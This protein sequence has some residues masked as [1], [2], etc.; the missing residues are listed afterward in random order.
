MDL[1]TVG[2]VWLNN[3]NGTFTATNFSSPYAIGSAVAVGDFNGDQKL[4][5]AASA[6]GVSIFLGHGNGRLVFLTNYGVGGTALAMADFDGNTRSDLVTL[7][8]YS[9]TTVLSGNG[10]GTFAPPAN[11]L[12]SPYYRYCVATG[13]FNRDGK[14]DIVTGS[15]VRS[16]SVRLNNGDGTFG[17]QKTVQVPI[18]VSAL[19]VADFDGDGNL[20]IVAG[21]PLVILPGNGDGTFASP[22]TN[23]SN[24]SG[25][26]GANQNLVVADFDGDGRPDIATTSVTN[27]CVSILLNRTAPSVSIQNTSG[28]LVLNWTDQL[29]FHLEFTTNLGLPH[30]WNAVTNPSFVV[31]GQR[32]VVTTATSGNGFF[33]LRKP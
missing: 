19:A 32:I 4:D 22:V 25:T 29:G 31:N 20:D 23:L 2:Q 7:N 24:L 30:S 10:D 26:E 11:Y 5:L 15:Y 17:P 27:N 1:V 18:S 12:D 14:P 3:G 9:Y 6:S 28:L 13:D 16:I 8:S 33:R 21:N